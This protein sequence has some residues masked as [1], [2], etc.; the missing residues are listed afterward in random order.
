LCFLFVMDAFWFLLRPWRLHYASHAFGLL[1]GAL[2]CA[3]S[4]P[5]WD[6]PTPA[7]RYRLDLPNV[8]GGSSH[9]KSNGI[10]ARIR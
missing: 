10:H 7:K 5:D 4:P 2:R 3:A 8:G 1:W 9:A 6:E